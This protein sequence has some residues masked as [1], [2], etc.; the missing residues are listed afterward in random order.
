MR[1]NFSRN[2]YNAI[3]YLA[4]SLRETIGISLLRKLQVIGYINYQR[5][6]LLTTWSDSWNICKKYIL[7]NNDKYLIYK[8]LI[9]NM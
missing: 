4:K 3:L 7:L 9:S 6:Q 2:K 8:Y 5:N 1:I